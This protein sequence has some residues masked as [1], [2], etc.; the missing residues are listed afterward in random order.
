MGTPALI[1]ANFDQSEMRDYC[2]SGVSGIG[3]IR[4]TM[5]LG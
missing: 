5:L 4:A 2:I 1:S 3:R